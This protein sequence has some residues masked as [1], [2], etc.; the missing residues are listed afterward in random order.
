MDGQSLTREL[1]DIIREDPTTSGFMRKLASYDW[2]Y[3]AAVEITRRTQCLTST[4]TITT[5]YNQ[6]TYTLNAD[7]L[8]LYLKNQ[9]N[10]YFIK[11]NDGTNTFFITWRDFDAIVMG[12]QTTPVNLPS[13]FCIIDSPTVPAQITGTA[14]SGGTLTNSESNLNDSTAPF[15]T[16]S[17]GDEVHNTTSVAFDGIVLAV[18]STSQLLTAVFTATDGVDSWSTSD[19][20]VI[21]PQG[22]KQLYLDPPP[23]T[24]GHTITVQFIQKPAP[25]YSPFRTYRFDNLA[26]GVLVKYAAFLYKYRDREPNFGDGFY[27]F[28]EMECARA[29]KQSGRAFNRSSFKV[30]FI[31]RSFP[32]RSFR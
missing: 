31:K 19:A 11:Y 25:V 20:Y 30:N 5:V 26:K 8:W 28:F 6:R 1:A 27:K 9:R 22:R 16:V 14:T 3:Q 23:L 18:T 24:S 4:Q 32:D 17:V 21:V 29:V 15:A 13:K 2:L 7:F 10:E 12:N